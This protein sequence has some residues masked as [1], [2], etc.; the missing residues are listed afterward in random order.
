MSGSPS[1]TSARTTTL[2][3]SITWWL[4]PRLARHQIAPPLGTLPNERSPLHSSQ[5]GPASFVRV[6]APMMSG[7]L[8]LSL[9]WRAG[10]VRAHPSRPCLRSVL[11]LN[12]AL[13]LGEKL[14]GGSGFLQ[15]QWMVL[16]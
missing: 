3:N 2:W 8:V 5:C 1:K 16:Q 6:P 12:P 4:N 15:I 13:N 14:R 7:L 10:R 9:H 11:G